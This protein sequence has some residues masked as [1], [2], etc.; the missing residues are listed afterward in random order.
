MNPL[1]SAKAWTGGISAALIAEYIEPSVRWGL[2]IASDALEQCC[3]RPMPEAMQSGLTMLALAGI[4]GLIIYF[5]PN[6]QTKG[7]I[8]APSSSAGA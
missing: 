1:I 6:A 2:D 5:V 4:V 7:E 3:Q 8:N